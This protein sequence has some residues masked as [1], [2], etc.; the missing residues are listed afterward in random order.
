[1]RHTLTSH[2]PFESIVDLFEPAI[3]EGQLTH[4]L[5]SSLYRGGGPWTTARTGPAEAIAGEA[6]V[7]KPE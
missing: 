1:M 3:S 4:P 5:H 6:V 2:I 7:A